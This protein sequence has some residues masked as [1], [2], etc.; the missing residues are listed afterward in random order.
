MALNISFYIYATVSKTIHMCLNFI[1]L[2]CVRKSQNVF[3][4]SSVENIYT[5]VIGSRAGSSGAKNENQY[6]F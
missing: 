3:Q 4:L 1:I 6:G 2:M 5:S